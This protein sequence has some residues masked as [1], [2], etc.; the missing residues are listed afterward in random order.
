MPAPTPMPTPQDPSWTPEAALR[1]L[2]ALPA[3]LRPRRIAAL[4]RGWDADVFLV[5][6]EWVLRI[7]RNEAAAAGFERELLFSA[8]L[9]ERLP[10]AIPQPRPERAGPCGIAD[11]RF[12]ICP[13][14]PGQTIT[15]ARLGREGRAALAKQLGEFVAALHALDPQAGPAPLDEDPYD[16]FDAGARLPKTL[17]SLELL[18]AG[19]V[20]P[21][22]TLAELRQ[23]LEAGPPPPPEPPRKVVVHADLHRR[24]LLVG[25]DSRLTGVIDWVDLHLGDRAADLASIF[26]VLPKEGYDDFLAA[27]GEVSPAELGRAR[28]RAAVHMT[29]ALEGSLS[30]GDARFAESC[31]SAL[32]EMLE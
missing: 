17:H 21:P 16:R 27:Y 32:V 2:G 6:D 4:G 29:L 22:A 9:G 19:D 8:W 31:R 11:W 13:L 23:L 15:D 26:E 24:N 25:S 20:L 7:P 10:I 18:A 14:L 12:V 3:A 5:D 28:W 30:R 1:L